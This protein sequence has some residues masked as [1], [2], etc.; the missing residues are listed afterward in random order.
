[1]STLAAAGIHFFA[2][3]LLLL[4]LPSL[5]FIPGPLSRPFPSSCLFTIREIERE[6]HV[7]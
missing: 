3:A 6:G 1:V 2:F 4:L 7:Y 5:F